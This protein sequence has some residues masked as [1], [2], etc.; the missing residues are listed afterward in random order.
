MTT[1]SFILTALEGLNE[2]LRLAAIVKGSPVLGFLP[3]LEAVFFCLKVPRSFHLISFPFS[4]TSN[5]TV[6]VIASRT[7]VMPVFV[8]PVF[9]A[10]T[11]K[12]E[13]ENN[14]VTS[15]CSIIQ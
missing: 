11:V 4:K 10:K 1:Y 7:L 9:S 14:Q 6:S 12:C 13:I 2:I 3:A 8:K 5:L 15:Y